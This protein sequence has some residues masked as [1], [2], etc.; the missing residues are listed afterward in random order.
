[1]FFWLLFYQL[2]IYANI[3]LRLIFQLVKISFINKFPPPHLTQPL[4]WRINF[5]FFIHGCCQWALYRIN[6]WMLQKSPRALSSRAS[7]IC[8]RAQKPA[9]HWRSERTGGSGSPLPFLQRRLSHLS[10]EFLF[11]FS[12]PLWLSS[13]TLFVLGLTLQTSF[14]TDKWSYS[15]LPLVIKGGVTN[16]ITSIVSDA[17]ART[18]T[19]TQGTS[20]R[21][22]SNHHWFWWCQ[23]QAKQAVMYAHTCT[24][25]NCIVLFIYSAFITGFRGQ[26]SSKTVN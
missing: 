11:R 19:H 13:A 8:H 6:M 10:V 16:Q 23:D 24:D 7:H 25:T 12:L 17:H 21:T 3:C 5:T 1:M 4:A 15:L 22:D 9:R 20:A 2:N 26:L 14:Y 18:H